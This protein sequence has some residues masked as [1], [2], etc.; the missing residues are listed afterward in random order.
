[1]GHYGTRLAVLLA[2]AMMLFWASHALASSWIDPT[3]EDMVNDS[4]LIIYA[5]VIK[6]GKYS[7]RV[8]AYEALKGALPTG[9]IVVTGFNNS[10]WPDR[11]ISLETFRSGEQYLLFIRKVEYQYYQGMP[12]PLPFGEN[13]EDLPKSWRK[14]PIYRVPTPTSGDYHVKNNMIFGG[15]G[16]APRSYQSPS[17]PISF[18]FPLVRALAHSSNNA[19]I[20]A[21]WKFLRTNLTSD[22]VKQTATD[23]KQKEAYAKLDWLLGAQAAFGNPDAIEPVL[24][25][26][27]LKDPEIRLNAARALKSLEPTA[28]VLK[29]VD[30]LLFATDGDVSTFL[31]A[32]AVRA[33]LKFDPNGERAVD[34]I[35]RA[36]PTSDPRG[37]GPH[38]IMDPV[39]NTKASGREL[40]IRALTHYRAN[41]AEAALIAILKRNDNSYE[42]I[43]AL[44]DHFALFQCAAA[45]SEI[46]SRFSKLEQNERDDYYRYFVIDGDNETLDRVFELTLQAE[47]AYDMK[48]LIEL[49]ALRCPRQDLRLTRAMLQLFQKHRGDGDLVFAIP[50]S[51]SLKSDKIDAEILA[52]D[53]A[54]LS[55][56][57]AETIRIVSDA[58]KLLNNPP[59][60]PAEQ[61]NGWLKLLE[62]DRKIGYSTEYL[63]RELVCS[64]PTGMR[65]QLLNRLETGDYGYKVD[66]A[67]MA[68]RTG[69]TAVIDGSIANFACPS[70]K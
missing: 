48:S 41:R 35:I 10:N 12:V 44:L 6:G 22:L 59:K 42:V 38:G 58:R 19:D 9:D 47:K 69:G 31:Q 30:S 28:E 40:M 51:L 63:L 21:G 29:A 60:D 56:G 33:L 18:V 49:Y 24:A 65:I 26:A 27:S 45:R 55:G 70:Q 3:F 62:R 23:D 5:K 57:G 52:I 43:M 46:F 1:M 54:T 50:I 53:A 32:E 67:I 64:T 16:W 17:A 20:D 14:L 66:S 2:A 15:W 4:D 8:H 13:Q 39:R 61:M 11:G 7:A 37:S 25:A 34:L 36:L 68:L